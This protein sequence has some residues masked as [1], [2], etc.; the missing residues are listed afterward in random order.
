MSSE[1]FAQL[2]GLPLRTELDEVFRQLFES[3]G[4][5]L[6]LIDRK[7]II[8]LAN[9][10][11]EELLGY[12]HGEMLGLAVDALVPPKV[13]GH[14]GQLRESYHATPQRRSMGSGLD[15]EACRKD[16][17]LF[18]VEISLNTF[19]SGDEELVMAFI[20]DITQRKR[21]ELEL[22]Q[23]NAELE[24]RVAER[25]RELKESQR[26]YSLIARNFPNGTINVF[27]ANYDYV[28][29]DG[30]ALS[31]QGLST[32]MLIGTNYLDRL[33]PD[34][35]PFVKSHLDHVFDGQD[36]AFQFQSGQQQYELQCV[37]LRSI[38]GEIHQILVVEHDIT[39]IK[40]AEEDIRKMLEKEKEL[41]ELKSRFV[42]MASHEFR[43]PLSTILSSVSL[44][45]RYSSEADTEKREKHIARIRSSVHNLTGILNDFLSLD[46]LEAG[47]I[48]HN[49][50]E[51]E[52]LALLEDVAEEMQA[53]AKPHQRIVAGLDGP[54]LLNL[55]GI[56]LRNV[57]VNL[58]SNAI[59][60]SPEGSE[61][62][63][64]GKVAGSQLQV[65]VHDQGVGI[66]DGEQLFLFQRFFRAKNVTNIQG[67]GLGLTI[68]K[69]Y[70]DLLGGDISFESKENL[71]ST[72]TIT[73][74]IIP[75]V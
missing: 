71:G 56:L 2:S 32:E 67:T 51:I 60:Y 15:L 28:F 43:T 70:L 63:M 30:R 64:L 41:N 50:K 34:L 23:L 29:V 7:G 13:R 1:H 37:G 72:F 14:H 66:P 9:R 20:T 46:R 5:G 22:E 62:S 3:A 59:K 36:R 6:L 73:L 53:I 21:A 54:T 61:V 8:L 19:R 49:P 58:V 75:S 10:R 69:K 27:D 39:Q 52:V 12:A 35:A 4:E 65:S 47:G 25:T 40:Q 16:G 45:A 17:T 33:G 48:V 74:P 11:A 38:S 44:C 55:D 68:V 18:P 26:L 57:L 42:S 24:Q 31:R